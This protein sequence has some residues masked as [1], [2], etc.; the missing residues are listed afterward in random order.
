M[1]HLVKLMAPQFL[2]PYVK[3][4]KND[5]VA[6]EAICEA[7]TRPPMRFVAMKSVQQQFMLSLH[8]VRSLLVAER[9]AMANQ[10]PVDDCQIRHCHSSGHQAS[11]GDV[12]PSSVFHREHG[13][14]PS[15][16][17]DIWLQLIYPKSHLPPCILGASIY[18]YW[19][20]GPTMGHIELSLL[21][22]CSGSRSNI[23]VLASGSNK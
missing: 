9:T 18:V 13:P 21:R 15:K 1:G 23:V 3:A 10:T 2:K 19:F 17:S 22:L 4:N 6:A 14:R 16:S 7:V 20:C 12:V 8:R 5:A 11:Y